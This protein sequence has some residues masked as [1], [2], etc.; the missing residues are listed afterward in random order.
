[1]KNFRLL[2]IKFADLNQLQ[3]VYNWEYL[4]RNDI[5]K[6]DLRIIYIHDSRFSITL[7]GFDGLEKWYSASP[8]DLN[9]ILPIIQQMPM[10]NVSS[11]D[12]TDSFNFCGLP[13][14]SSTSHCFHDETH[15]T[16]CMLGKQAREYADKSGNPIGAA[17][18]QAFKQYYGFY[19]TPNTLTPW[20]TCIGS[21]VCTFYASKFKDGTHVKF[22]DRINGGI[23]L[24]NDENK[25][26]TLTHSTPGVFNN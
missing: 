11:R 17:S 24:R 10:G 23:I 25:Y 8:K 6:K 18:V 13:H 16:C 22:I 7:Y 26:K 20:C 3:S 5:V 4:N 19:P 1:M 2:Q 12:K 14:I 15:R 21:K 9:K